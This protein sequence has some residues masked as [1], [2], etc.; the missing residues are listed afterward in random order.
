MSDGPTAA[1]LAY[2]LANGSDNRGP[3]ITISIVTLT[4]LSIVFVFLRFITR[5]MAKLYYW[6]DDY[7]IVLALV[8]TA[9]GI[10]GSLS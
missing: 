9:G 1:Q 2:Q 8:S 3:D 4:V 6:W 7:A 5:W 10:A